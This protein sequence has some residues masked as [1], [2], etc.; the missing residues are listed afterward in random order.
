MDSMMAYGGNNILN[1]TLNKVYQKDPSKFE[2][3]GSVK[4]FNY[5]FEITKAPTAK[6]VYG[7]STHN[8]VISLK[9]VNIKIAPRVG[10]DGPS[11]DKNMPLTAE[12]KLGIS[13]GIFSFT[14]LV[15]S[16][17]NPDVLEA[18]FVEI[19]NEKVVPKIEDQL[20]AVTLPQ[21]DNLFHS[22]LT[23][24]IHTGQV[25]SGPAFEIGVRITGNTSIGVADAPAST[26]ISSLNSGTATNALVVAM[27]SDDAINVLIKS[28][29][30]TITKSYDERETNEYGF[31]SAI[32]GTLTITTPVLNITNGSGKVT[33][34]V[35]VDLKAGIQVPLLDWGWVTLFRGVADVEVNN[36]LITQ[37]NEAMMKLNSIAS[38]VIDYGLPPEMIPVEKEVISM[39]AKIYKNFTAKVNSALQERPPIHLFNLPSTIPGSSTPATL[40]FDPDGFTYYKNSV[41]ALVR[42]KT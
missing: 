12:G 11:I 15:V 10:I 13:D 27:I 7:N 42:I 22:S 1:L 37:G 6:L 20:K 4:G 28:L 8:I 34:H 39:Y 26:N 32:T 40:S 30:K 41:R 2:G 5:S 23:A 16:I 18:I 31:G 38:L 33:A 36:T 24:E 14:S 35:S 17:D 29:N 3:S 9:N 19:I 25:I 21:L